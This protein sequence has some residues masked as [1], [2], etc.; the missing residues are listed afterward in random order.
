VRAVCCC[1]ALLA[2][3]RSRGAAV[4]EVSWAVPG[5]D[6]AAAALMGAPDSFLS[7]TR[8][9]LY[10]TKRNDPGVPQVRR[11]PGEACPR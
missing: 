6:A 10:A 11:A 2:E 8:L 4:P 5:E 3:V 9:A 7:P 1:Q